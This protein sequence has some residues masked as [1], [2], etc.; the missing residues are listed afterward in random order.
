MR[1]HYGRDSLPVDGNV[2]AHALHGGELVNDAVDLHGRHRRPLE[3]RQKYAAQGVSEGHAEATLQR[4]GSH[5]G[6]AAAVAAG[7]DQRL[8]RT[9]KLLPISFDHDGLV[10]RTGPD[11]LEPVGDREAASG[12]I[13]R[14]SLRR[15]GAWAGGSRCA[16][17]ASRHGSS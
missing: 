1:K 12:G 8:L 9:D 4:F 13:V 7:F 14:S 15:D 16:G 6:L 5:T 3:G 2:L 17:S 11:A 10:S